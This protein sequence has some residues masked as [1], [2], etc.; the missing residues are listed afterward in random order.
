MSICSTANFV[1]TLGTSLPEGETH[2]GRNPQEPRNVRLGLCIDDFAPHGQYGRTYSCWSVIITPYNLSPAWTWTVNDLS[3]YGMASGWNT[4][5]VMGCPICMDDTRAFHLQ[6][7]DQIFNWVANI[8]PTVEMSLSLPCSY[9]S[10]HKR[11]KKSIFW[12]LPYC[13]MLM[14]R[15]N[16]NVIHI[17]KNVFDDIFN[18]VMNIKEKTKDNMNTRRDLKIICKHPELELDKSRPNVMTKAFYTMAKE[19]K[20]RVCEWICGLNFSYGYV[21]NLARCIDMIELRMHGMK[22]HDCHVFMQKLILTAFHEMLLSIVAIILCNLENIIP[23]A[24]FDS[25][26]HF[27]VHLPYEARIGRLVHYRWMYPFEMF[28]GELK[29]KVKNKSLVE[30]FIVKVYIVKEIALFTSQY[31]E[32]DVQS[33]RRMPRRNDERMSSDDGYI[34]LLC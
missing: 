10:D 3:T 12:D 18:M 9:G 34:L 27:I 20:R 32:P 15:H 30:A 24:F 5:R 31:F 22:S 8:S 2:T 25:I 28:I 11:A 14:I 23:P 17:K 29:K 4:A 19:Q 21:Y 6:H 7:G 1:R 16:L 33:K 26:E 13:S